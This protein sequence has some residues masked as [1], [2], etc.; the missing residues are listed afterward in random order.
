MANKKSIK[1]P[2]L[3]LNKRPRSH[4][5]EAIKIIK[6]NLAFSSIDREIKKVLIT[7]PE[8]GDGKSFISSN[9]ALAY[10]QEGKKVLIIDC[11]MRKGRLHKIFNIPNSV[12]SG[13][14]NLIL[15]YKNIFELKEI[16]I[17]EY[18]IPT[19]IKNLHV[20]PSGPIPPNPVELL[21]SDSNK[22]LLDN[23]SSKY[24]VIILDCPPV[25]GLSD[26]VIQSKNSDYNILVVSSNKTKETS[27][28]EAKKL[29]EQANSKI[30]GV[31]LNKIK[32]KKNS[33]YYGNGER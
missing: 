9:L 16:S 18:I 22:N 6:T 10:V 33:Y 1:S 28:K 31:V 11:D 4:F 32:T 13:Y 12:K 30:N 14:S 21:C 23:L 8:P 3:I 25:V 20:I 27:L 26:A 15:N 29:F 7:S 17:S 5:A 24:D 2:D 19:E